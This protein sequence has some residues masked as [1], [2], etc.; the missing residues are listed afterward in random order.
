MEADTGRGLEWESNSYTELL[1]LS[2]PIALSTLSYSLMTLVDTFLVSHL[3]ASALA[4]VGLGGVFAFGIL[5]F[6]FGVLRGVKTLVSQ[7]VGAKRPEEIGAY[8]GAGLLLA[9]GFGV[10][11]IAAA[12]LLGSLL[13]L[14]AATPEA[15]ENART[16][17]QIRI[18]GAPAVLAYV[19]L[20]ET[21]YGKGDSHTPMFATLLANLAN[22]ALSCWFILGLGMGVEG[23]AWSTACAHLVEAAFL[24]I[25]Q[26]KEGWGIRSM[27]LSHLR[28]LWRIGLPTGIQFTL[29]VGSFVA[30]A[31]LISAMG[32]EE[33]AA[34]QIALQI[35]HV[36]FLPAMAVAEATS[37]LAGQAVGA[38]R[39][40]LVLRV[41]RQG[42]W[43]A[44]GY[45]GF[46]TLI[47]A[48]GAPWLVGQF[49]DAAGLASIAT[50]LLYVAALFQVFDGAN[51]VARST[52]R[53]TGDVRVPAVIGILTAWVL[54]PPLTWLLGHQLGLGALGGWVGLCIEIILGSLILWRRLLRRDWLEAAEKT[55]ARLAAEGV[56]LAGSTA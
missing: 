53:G 7:A 4:G 10:L 29:E 16:Y 52:L 14:I 9:L 3:G 23:A 46:C 49:T 27:T 35:I 31:S 11:A 56:G 26:Q 45:T 55:R 42:M 12:H 38:R 51:M 20:R 15:A 40:E 50:R 13:G 28:E 19:A 47:L 5:C 54:T 39:E 37:V 33:M 21:R 1:R 48:L 2:W 34:H 18:L 43:L 44:G 24:G 25:A 41:A 30:L 8:L 6:L 36:S 17:L 32:E 22:I